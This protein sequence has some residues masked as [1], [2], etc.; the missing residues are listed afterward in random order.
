MNENNDK[1]T[2][3]PYKE[4]CNVFTEHDGV[5]TSCMYE[6]EIDNKMIQLKELMLKAHTDKALIKDKKSLIYSVAEEL[7][8]KCI[9]KEVNGKIEFAI[10]CDKDTPNEIGAKW[11][12]TAGIPNFKLAIGLYELLKDLN[13]DPQKISFSWPTKT[14]ERQFTIKCDEVM[15]VGSLYEKDKL[16]RKE[17]VRSELLS[18]FDALCDK[19]INEWDVTFPNN[20]EVTMEFE[21]KKEIILRIQT[22]LT[23]QINT[24]FDKDMGERMILKNL[25]NTLSAQLRMIMITIPREELTPRAT[26]TMTLYHYLISTKSGAFYKLYQELKKSGKG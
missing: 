7:G 16:E 17:K 22:E 15:E 1:C 13:L 26:L 18:L 12:E 6:T 4:I 20:E 8:L 9:Y 5:M 10:I 24:M 21:V 11:K 19:F 14:G 25:I 23:A 3:C 2:T